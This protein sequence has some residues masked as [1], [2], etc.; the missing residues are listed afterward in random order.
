MEREEFP[1][2]KVDINPD[3]LWENAVT[4]DVANVR[5]FNGN[6][7]RNSLPKNYNWL[8]KEQR[9]VI[10]VDAD[11]YT[12]VDRL[13][14]YF[15]EEARMTANRSMCIT[16][17]DYY[18][19]NYESI[20]RKARFRKESDVVKDRPLRYYLENILYED[21]VACTN[22]KISL[23]KCVAKYFKAK[24]ILDPSAGWGDRMLG[25]AAAGV[26]CY[27]SV[28]PNPKLIKGYEEIRNFLSTKGVD[29]NNFTMY[30]ADFLKVDLQNNAYDLVFTSPPFF[31]YEI[32]YTG[33]ESENARQSITN[34]KDL[35]TWFNDFFSEYLNKSWKAL[36]VGG[37]MVL[38]ISDIPGGTFITDMINYVSNVLGGEHLGVIAVC[39]LSNKTELAFKPQ[40]MWVW[41][42]NK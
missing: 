8:F 3:E 22:F 2:K 10:A 19:Q 25:A 5:I 6:L 34:R 32:Y 33:T 14:D 18:T 12:V 4:R 39:N 26:D 35:R 31:D 11:G 42:K 21:S 27:H 17:Y 41:R 13:T 24:K 30:P 15:T 1:Y 36:I 28:D 37:H 40:P 7:P 23:T 38:Y 9:V 16:P 20:I 29:I